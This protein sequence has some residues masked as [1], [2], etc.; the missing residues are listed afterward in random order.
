MEISK[1]KKKYYSRL[2]VQVYNYNSDRMIWEVL[3]SE[4][5]SP[6]SDI[7]YVFGELNLT[8]LEGFCQNNPSALSLCQAS[9]WEHWDAERQFLFE[10]WGRQGDDSHCYPG[11]F[12]WNLPVLVLWNESGNRNHHLLSLQQSMWKNCLWLPWAVTKMM[13]RDHGLQRLFIY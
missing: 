7:L 8:L 3:T 11:A 5:S 6:Q 2:L 1:G 10:L 4:N 12:S 9:H 13:L